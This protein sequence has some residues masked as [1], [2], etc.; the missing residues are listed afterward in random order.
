MLLCCV[1]VLCSNFRNR[2]Y[3]F[4]LTH[5][6]CC[7]FRP[8]QLLLCQWRGK[9]NVDSLKYFSRTLYN[10]LFLSFALI[11]ILIKFDLMDHAEM[12]EV[13]QIVI[14]ARRETDTCFVLFA[15]AFVCFKFG[16]IAGKRWR[17]LVFALTVGLRCCGAQQGAVAA[18]DVELFGS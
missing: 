16:I 9:T 2:A 8:L 18:L 6:L 10:N 13:P 17:E 15:C 5:T 1:V 14:I 12:W 11:L 4:D 3:C 7:H